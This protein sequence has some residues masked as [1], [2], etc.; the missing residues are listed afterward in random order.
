M[1]GSLPVD[2]KAEL[3]E[4]LNE[5]LAAEYEVL[6]TAKIEADVKALAVA[7]L[8]LLQPQQDKQDLNFNGGRHTFLNG[9]CILCMKFKGPNDN[10]N[11][12]CP[13]AD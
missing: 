3:V 12:R 4:R 6:D 8:S 13:E 7:V 1:S 5:I 10:P 2:T 11:E 9:R